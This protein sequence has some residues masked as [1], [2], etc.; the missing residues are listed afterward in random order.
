MAKN[1]IQLITPLENID[2][3]NITTTT[4]SPY[5]NSTC[6]N[7]IEK[8]SYDHQQQPGPGPTPPLIQAAK[9][10]NSENSNF[11]IGSGPA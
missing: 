7:F 6:V 11:E 8:D 10:D 3:R 4:I 9:L 2:N 1:L 5:T